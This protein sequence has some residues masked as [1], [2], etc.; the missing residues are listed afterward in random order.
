MDM[1]LGSRTILYLYVYH[2]E[3]LMI[4]LLPKV[5]GSNRLKRILVDNFLVCNLN[6]KKLMLNSRYIR[7][8]TESY[9]RQ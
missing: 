9:G 8:T 7:S 6:D 3:K 1:F 5:K 2:Y 4:Y